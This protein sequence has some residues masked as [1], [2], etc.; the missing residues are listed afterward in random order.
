MN[1][2]LASIE[3]QALELAAN[4]ARAPECRLRT[5]HTETM[6]QYRPYQGGIPATSI[7]WRQSAKGRELLVREHEKITNRDTYFWACFDGSEGVREQVSL[8]LL[9]LGHLL[10]KKE[11]RIGWLGSGRPLTQTPSQVRPL[12]EGGLATTADISAPNLYNACVLLATDIT[13]D[14][15]K[16][17][18]MLNA[19]AAQGGKGILF[20]LGNKKPLAHDDVV[21]TTCK[22]LGWPIVIFDQNE[23][24]DSCLLHLFEKSIQATR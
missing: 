21:S 2:A 1:P 12:F 11:R 20:H 15:E 13:N 7:D 6:W 3:R 4:L 24:A 18:R 5:N 23:R 16:L 17:Q 14:T 8:I 22:K 10:V 9:A 19:C